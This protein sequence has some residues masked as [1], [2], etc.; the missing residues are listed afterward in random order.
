MKNFLPLISQSPLFANVSP[1]AL[2]AMLNCIHAHRKNFAKG[3][4][5]YPPKENISELALVLSGSVLLSNED[6]FGNK[7][8]LDKILPGRALRRS[9]RRLESRSA[10]ERTGWRGE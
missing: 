2:P 6:F 3:Q 10:D 1:D 4:F 7:N 5:I 9:L 8:V